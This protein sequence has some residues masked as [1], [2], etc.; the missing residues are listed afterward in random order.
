MD[1]AL[2]VWAKG[3]SGAKELQEVFLSPLREEKK[4][5]HLRFQEPYCQQFPLVSPYQ[6]SPN[7]ARLVHSEHWEY[8]GEY[9]HSRRSIPK[10]LFPKSPIANGPLPIASS[11]NSL[12]FVAVVRDDAM[13]LAVGVRGNF[14]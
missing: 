11:H 9:N 13:S 5:H 4:S 10:G 3:E 2:A 8:W 1:R 14:P 12:S 6:M 7:R